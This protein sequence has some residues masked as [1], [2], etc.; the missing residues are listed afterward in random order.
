MSRAVARRRSG[1]AH[2]VEVGGHELIA[3]EPVEVGGTDEGAS[4]TD[5]LAISLAS[6]TAITITL[7]A[8]RK[9]W[10]IDGLEVAVDFPGT[11]D[12]G[13]PAQFTVEVEL[14]DGLDQDQRDRIMVIAGKCPVHRIL[15]GNV[16]I[17]TRAAN[18]DG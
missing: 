9:G 10:D 4:P 7:Y 8:D 2:T 15:L 16:E 13:E 3:D 1:L 14:P 18:P 11:P 17:D 5:L 12:R 6:C